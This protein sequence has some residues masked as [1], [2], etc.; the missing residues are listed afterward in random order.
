MAVEGVLNGWL[1][2]SDSSPLN[3]E[4]S[5][6]VAKWFMEYRA[7]DPN[8][9]KEEAVWNGENKIIPFSITFWDG[10]PPTAHKDLESMC[11]LLKKGSWIL[12]HYTTRNMYFNS[13]MQSILVCYDGIRTVDDTAMDDPLMHIV[14]G[15]IRGEAETEDNPDKS[16]GEEIDAELRTYDPSPVSRV[17]WVD[18]KDYETDWDT[19]DF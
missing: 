12:F 5:A 8:C 2:L 11:H 13:T 3:D 14:K 4:E 9:E 18:D 1:Q 15:P 7:A 6:G 17:D 19:P 16:S 10:W